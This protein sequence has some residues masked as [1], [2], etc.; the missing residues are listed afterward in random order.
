ME[1][2]P[3]D[4]K[5][6]IVK[7]IPRHDTAQIIHD[8]RH[9]LSLYYIRGYKYENTPLYHKRIWQELKPETL[10]SLFYGDNKQITRS[11][12]SKGQLIKLQIQNRLYL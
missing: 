12:V 2:L 11:S 3:I 6:E 1:Q 5:R 8:S 7:F 10:K 9:N 4:V